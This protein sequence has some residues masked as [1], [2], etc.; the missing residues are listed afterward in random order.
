MFTKYLYC[1]LRSVLVDVN[2]KTKGF[3]FE[4]SD[5]GFRSLA[6]YN[7]D[8]S[9]LRS[10]CANEKLIKDFSIESNFLKCDQVPRVQITSN[11]L[12]EFNKVIEILP[13]QY[14]FIDF[15]SYGSENNFLLV[16]DDILESDS[17]TGNRFIKFEHVDVSQT[18][19]S[20]YGKVVDDEE[21]FN[22]MLIKMKDNKLQLAKFYY[23]V[24]NQH[25]LP[26]W[27]ERKSE[28]VKEIKINNV[29]CSVYTL[30]EIPLYDNNVL[31][32]SALINKAMTMRTKYKNVIGSLKEL[33]S[34]L[35]IMQGYQIE[36]KKIT[37]SG[38]N[39]SYRTDYGVYLKSSLQDLSRDNKAS[40]VTWY[41]ELIGSC[42][43]EDEI[44]SQI[45]SNS[46]SELIKTAML[47]IHNVMTSAEEITDIIMNCNSAIE[48]LR[49]QLLRCDIFLYKMRVSSYFLGRRLAPLKNPVLAGSDESAYTVVESKLF[50]GDG[51]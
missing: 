5:G 38:G 29:D 36:D 15:L 23:A 20:V 47:M 50:Y 35:Y 45:M 24:D 46:K 40:C 44:I 4:L 14:T 26:E 51:F 9:G 32:S 12:A 22:I 6:I 25:K 3:C 13:E 8:L 43:S 41:T 1:Y 42:S 18:T 49:K 11:D 27:I 30:T 39:N 7:T 31:L 21:V 37:W 33:L 16:S 2:D 17:Y 28:Y 19:M 48:D 34:T 10:L